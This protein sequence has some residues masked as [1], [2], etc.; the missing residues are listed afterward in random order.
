MMSRA[1]IKSVA[2]LIPDEKTAARIK[3]YTDE[4]FGN[5]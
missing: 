5:E 2:D 1:K 3:K 4:A